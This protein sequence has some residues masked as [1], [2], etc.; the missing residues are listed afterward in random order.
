MELLKQDI[1]LR[2]ETL[3]PYLDSPCDIR[4]TTHLSHSHFTSRLDCD[5]T[6]Q[7]MNSL[8]RRGRS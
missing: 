5:Q 3:L 2:P 4:V 7:H 8:V 6:S 1:V